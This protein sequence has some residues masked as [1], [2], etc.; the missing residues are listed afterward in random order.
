MS[1]E[2]TIECPKCNHVFSADD[3]LQNHLKN[4]QLEIQKQLKDKEKQITDKIKADFENKEKSLKQKVAQEIQSKNKKIIENL[5]SEIQNFDKKSKEIKNKLEAEKQKEKK[6]WEERLQNAEK[7][8][9]QFE[10]KMQVD[11]E[12]KQKALEDKI[13][14][15]EKNLEKE[16]EKKLKLQIEK[17]VEAKSNKEIERLQNEIL[18]KEKQRQI[19]NQRQEKRIN[20]MAKQIKQK[21]VEIQGEV[22]EELIEDFLRNRFPE[23][24]VEEIKKG[25]KGGDCIQT[26][27]HKGQNNLAQIYFE[28]KDHKNFKEEWVDKLL[29]DMKAKHINF[30]VLITNVMPKDTDKHSGYALRHGKRI[31]IIPMNYQIIH[32]LVDFLRRNLIR[33]FNSKKDFDAP[34][35]LQKLWDHITGPSFQLPLRKLFQTIGSMGE[36]IQKEKK[37]YESNMAKKERTLTD[38]EGD[39]RDLINSFSL[40]VG[41]VLPENMLEIE[42][43]KE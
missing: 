6:L 28:S 8:K 35:E 33:E 9:K 37:F 25:S 32:L 18:K 43:K 3:A 10:N 5:Q 23:D 39:F 34:K 36:L 2:L 1:K 29:N 20:E 40:K 41:N 31:M 24:T 4:K 42:N 16:I 7:T 30:G 11:F 21:S 15:Q 13:K 26:I 27:N 22:Q 38:M 17:N 12:K 14:V 19:E